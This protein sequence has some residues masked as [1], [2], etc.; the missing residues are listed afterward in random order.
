MKKLNI[1]L[2]LLLSGFG[3]TEIKAPNPKKECSV[4][5]HDSCD[6]GQICVAL[7]DL[8]HSGYCKSPVVISPFANPATRIIRY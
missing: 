7:K 3:I 2:L 6:R 4:E 8:P 1:V 5:E